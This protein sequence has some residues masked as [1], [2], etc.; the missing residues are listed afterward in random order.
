M[1]PSKSQLA[2][3]WPNPGPPLTTEAPVR[4]PG[5]SPASTAALREYLQKD[6]EQH[7]GFFNNRGFHNHT[8]FHLLVEWVLGGTPAHLSAIWDQ[9]VAIERPQ[10][11]SPHAITA[12][13]F[14]DHLGD[15]NYYQAYLYFFSDVVLRK[16]AHVVLEEW[17]FSSRVNY[18]TLKDGMFNRLLAGVMHP[19]IYVG[20]GLEFSLP[21]LVAE[22]L[23][24]AA[25]HKNSTSTLLPRYMFET[26]SVPRPMTMGAH[27]AGVHA[28]SILAR[29]Q[30][31]HRF[32]NVVPNFKFDDIHTQYGE[33]IQRYA[34]EWIVEG[35]DS[36]E[37]AEKVKELIFLN[38]M[39][40]AMGG[41]SEEKGFRYAEFT[42]MHLVT[43]SITM[44]SYM[45]SISTPASKT[46]LLRAYFSRSLAYW[47]SRGRPILNIR[48][49]FASSTVP[50]IPG[51]TPTP[52]SSAFPK[53]T[54]LGALTPNPWLQIIQ[55]A[56]VH[57]DDHL[58]KFQRTLAY[59]GALYGA[60]TAGEF[61]GTE[62][63]GSDYVDGT[64]FL[65]AAGL[66]MEKMGRVREGEKDQYWTNDPNFPTS[67]ASLR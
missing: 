63:D 18:D 31:E 11:Q 41:W 27:S 60:V 64:L 29:I 32:N 50:T 6:Y 8:P 61:K 65:R 4:W 5:I 49:F 66:T 62:L 35:M 30:R 16:P 52:Y 67:F 2:M 47:I 39:I 37:V 26:P 20:F 46:M 54:A 25:V 13:T 19:L 45:A 53:P 3:L 57:P 51:P 36:K 42:L 17:I 48:S 34:A 21:G 12:E 43:S 59:Y 10:F 15:E 9:H 40:Y 38:V 23:A 22:G 56:L 1:A 28:F 44:S 7:H 33:D 14:N 24:H 58:G 55:S